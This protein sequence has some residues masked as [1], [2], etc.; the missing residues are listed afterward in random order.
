MSQKAYR[1]QFD[2]DANIKD[3]QGKL[4][5]ISQQMGQIGQTSGTAQLQKQFDGLTAAVE[6]VRVKASSPITSKTEFASLEKELRGVENG[7]A[8]LLAL[9]TRLEGSTDKQKL[10]LLPSDQKK[11]ISDAEKALEKYDRTI[12][13]TAKDREELSKL[14]AAKTSSVGKKNAANTLL[15]K[16]NTDLKEAQKELKAT[17]ELQAELLAARD[18][19]SA[20]QKSAKA[21]AS[22]DPNNATAAA[23]AQ[24]TAEAYRKLDLQYKEASN[25]AKQAQNTVDQLNKEIKEQTTIAATAE[26]EITDLETKIQALNNAKPQKLKQAFDELKTAAQQIGGI[27]TKDITDVN[28]IDELIRRFQ[29]LSSDGVAEAEQAIQNFRTKVEGLQPTLNQSKGNLDQNSTAFKELSRSA[30]EMEN[31]KNQF[32]HFFSITNTVQLFKR[33]VQ[34]ALNTVKELDATMTEAAVVTDFSIGDMW[35]QLPRYSKEA[36]NLGVSINGMYQATTLYY[37]QGLK[38]NEAMQLGVETMKMAKIAAMDST[39]ATTAMTAALRGFNME[40]NETS[41]TRVNDVYSQLAAVTAAD[42]NQI[43][44]AMEKT[45]S[46]AASANM[47]FES[48]AALLAQIIETTQEAPETAGT[49]LKTIIARFSEVKS[50]ASQGLVS[51]EDSEGEVIDVNKIQTALRQ[52]GISMDGFFAGTEG[53]DSILIKLSEKWGTLD[54]ETQRYIA[55]MAAGSRQ[56]SRFLAMMGDYGRTMELVDFANN[57]A[58]ASQK[59]FE[60]TTE[61]LETSLNRLKN[62][63]NEFT[64]GLANNEFL[65]FAIDSLTNVLEIVNKITNGVSGNNGLVKSITSL[66]TVFGALKG[67]GALLSRAFGET[68]VGNIVKGLD[69]NG[70]KEVQKAG[71]NIGQGF[72]SGFN[73][74]LTNKKAG[75][76]GMKN[77]V[78]NFVKI[79]DTEVRT[80]DLDALKYD[81]FQNS[82]KEGFRELRKEMYD[83]NL[84]AEELSKRYQELGGNIEQFT[85]KTVPAQINLRGIG[86]AAMGAGAALGGLSALFSSLGMEDAAKATSFLA[87]SL[88]TLGS[89]MQVLTI[90]APKMGMSFTTAGIEIAGAAIPI[91]VAWWDVFLVISA[92]VGIIALMT[93]AIKHAKENSL[94]GRIKAAEEA[95]KNAKEAAEEAKQVYEELLGKK[96]EYNET[97]KSLENLTRGTEEW[98][99]ALLAANEEVLELISAYPELA[100]YLAR[101]GQGQLTIS[102]EGWKEAT[103]LRAQ[104]SKNSASAVLASQLKETSLQLQKAKKAFYDR[105]FDARIVKTIE[106]NTA[107]STYTTGYQ[108][109]IQAVDSDALEKLIKAYQDVGSELFTNSS[110]MEEFAKNVGYTVESLQ[111]LR[112]AT[113]AYDNELQKA[114]LTMQAQAEGAIMAQVSEE[115]ATY[116]YGEQA[117]AA[118]AKGYSGKQEAREAGIATQLGSKDF[119]QNDYFKNLAAEYGVSSKIGTDDTKNLETLYAAMAGVEE[120][121][122]DLKDNQKA[123]IA[124]ISKIQASKD[125]ANITDKLA[126]NLSKLA[127]EKQRVY[128]GLLSQDADIFKRSDLDINIESGYIDNMLDELGYSREQLASIMNIPKDEIDQYLKSTQENAIKTVEKIYKDTDDFLGQGITENLIDQFES[129]FA[130]ADL[131]IGEMRQLANSFQQIAMNGGEADEVVKL[132]PNLIAGLSGDKLTEAMNLLSTASWKTTSDINS[133]IEGLKDLGVTIDRK[134]I[135]Q[136]YHATDAIYD[137]NTAQL[138]EKIGTLGDSFELVQSKIQDNINTFSTEEIDKLINAGLAE[139]SNFKRIGY[140][141]FI[142]LQPIENLLKQIETNTSYLRTDAISGLAEKVVLGQNIQRAIEKEQKISLR[143][144]EIFRQQGRRASEDFFIQDVINAL[145]NDTLKVGNFEIDDYS[146][147]Q[148]ATIVGFSEKEIQNMDTDALADSILNRWNLVYGTG[149]QAFIQNQKDLNVEGEDL[150]D[151]HQMSYAGTKDFYNTIYNRGG[152]ST[153][154][155]ELMNKIKTDENFLSSEIN[156]PNTLNQMRSLAKN[157]NIADAENMEFQDLYAILKQLDDLEGA[158]KNLDALIQAEAGLK[159]MVENSTEALKEQG[160][161]VADDSLTVKNFVVK[162]D[163]ENDTMAALGKTL[164]ENQELLEEGAW[165]TERYSAALQKIGKGLE[166]V[167]G[168]EVTDEFI[169]Q[170][171]QLFTTILEGG[172]DSAAAYQELMA[173]YLWSTGE[174]TVEANALII[175]ALAEARKYGTIDLTQYIQ[176]LDALPGITEEIA[177][178]ALNAYFTTM[179]NPTGTSTIGSIRDYGSL[180]GGKSA[181]KTKKEEQPW[182]NPYDKFYNTTE[183]INE[184]LRQREKLERRYSKLIEKNQATADKLVASAKEELAV[185]AREQELQEKMISN[186]KWQIEKYISQKGLTKYAFLGENEFTGQAEL[187]INWSEI[188]KVTSQDRGE[189]IEEYISQLEEWFESIE[190]AQDSLEDIEDAVDEIKKRGEDEYFNFENQ[191]K[192]ALVAHYEKQIETLSQINDTINE[193]NSKL[194]ASMQDAISE[195]RQK[196]TNKRTEEDLQK[197]ASR[198]AYLKQDT[199]GGNDLEI[200][201]LEEELRQGQEDYTDTLIDQKINELQQQNEKAAEQRQQQIDIASDQLKHWQETGKVWEQVYALMHTGLEPITGKIIDKSQLQTLLKDSANFTGMSTLEKM[202]WLDNL[203][204]SVAQ[205]ISYLKTGRQLE[206]MEEYLGKAGQKVTFTTADGAT[207]T[208]VTD[209]HGNVKVGNQTYS[210]VYQNFDGGFRTDETTKKQETPQK[211]G[212]NKDEESQTGPAYSEP[213]KSNEPSSGGSTLAYEKTGLKPDQVKELQTW[214]KK[215]GYYSSSIDGKYGPGT[216]EAVRQF[217]KKE[218]GETVQG[219][220]GKRTYERFKTSTYSLLTGRT[221]DKATGMGESRSVTKGDFNY[222]PP[223]QGIVT[224]PWLTY[225]KG[226]VRWLVKPPKKGRK[227]A[228]LWNNLVYGIDRYKTGGLADY[229]GPAWLD[230][231]KSRPELVLNQRDTQNFIQLKDILSS[232]MSKPTKTSENS[233]D[234]TYDIDINVESIGNDYDVEQLAEKIKSLINQD[235]RYRNNNTINLL[236]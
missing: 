112:D 81:I 23:N 177:R 200:L 67:G 166:S 9:I 33:T 88:M 156:D 160:S 2:F 169:H 48:T 101:G 83:S 195:E 164:E 154:E 181:K 31:L 82:D 96:E 138:K 29:K 62:A 117:V 168:G 179:S 38:T 47:Q 150:A 147:K 151:W 106:A 108:A 20:D 208:G 51:G 130:E 233:G 24:Q 149:G 46:I 186:R 226:G 125:A 134:L 34:S 71:T 45:A 120:I 77:F 133:T 17:Q 60:K 109:P 28:Q 131:S 114:K 198:L 215:E 158:E 124:E 32:L 107:A 75:Q 98:T 35:A 3:L 41:A 143:D 129:S 30:Q 157:F 94:E 25:S 105:G 49:A 211:V 7:Y 57:S 15:T 236:R 192:D 210:G 184:A 175:K 18:R 10:D 222:Y 205:A 213:K 209:K 14:E 153:N 126:K 78:K 66:M 221:S 87:A 167:L 54:F 202:A 141:E 191:V 199:S 5:L 74:A 232:I 225:D 56:Q 65:K 95:T 197:K 22:K 44:T 102:E 12:K 188:N 187:R 122:D 204:G 170:H 72:V 214:L 203:E 97:Q 13:A 227:G 228:I 176:D 123:L 90:I 161:V 61:S 178:M 231:T 136:L 121:P 201:K 53:L 104:S 142:S 230:G 216:Q 1:I 27:E 152:L 110:M 85:T 113:I 119:H 73:N 58:G 220:E 93:L 116:Q 64:M 146:L 91:K 128:S 11:R 180:F 43:A 4:Q 86:T 55:T 39:E 148:L 42:T 52:V 69:K 235:A 182:E 207:L 132:I 189:K 159:G 155:N 171:R 21:K 63:W 162:I 6:R 173:Q 100:R 212:S 50:L 224:D 76:S 40:L 137:F 229:T 193:T 139:R 163:A 68:G 174:M 36:Q 217:W 89:V 145:Q 185:L 103:T 79:P 99:Q 70:N 26:A 190:E 8:N 37:Q 84:S 196:R 172:D 165:G 115:T 19:A 111:E 16:Y 135:Q 127:P 140:D 206:N 92:I 183:K 59:Q 223:L 118:V 144:S 218:Y 219:H 194:I 80:V 234:N